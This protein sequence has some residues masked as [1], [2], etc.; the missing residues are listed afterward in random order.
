MDVL[1]DADRDFVAGALVVKDGKILLIDHGKHDTW[2]QPGGH[3]EEGE[4]P[5][6]AAVRETVEE[7]GFDVEILD[8]FSPE[9]EEAVSDFPQQ[10]LPR[11]FDINIH[12]VREGH[13]HCDFLY[14]AEVK[15]KV[16]ASHSH[17]HGGI[18]WFS[19][20]ELAGDSYDIPEYLRKIGINAIEE[21]G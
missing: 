11:P 4:T 3:I 14:L 10:A 9:R 17:E 20:E 18:R 21:A 2:L 12:Q 8:I 7:T 19:R 15:Q 16:E 1:E 6:E 13:W 5:D